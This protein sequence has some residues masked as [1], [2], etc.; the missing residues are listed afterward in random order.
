MLES[1]AAELW[2]PIPGYEWY[3]A[4]DLGRIRSVP[5]VIVDR[6]GRTRRQRGCVLAPLWSGLEKRPA[7]QLGRGHRD[8]VYR[9]VLRTFVGPPPDGMEGCHEDGDVRN[10]KP[11]NLRWG[12][13]SS[14]SMDKQRHGTDHERNKTRCPTDHLLV[15]PNL[16]AHKVDVGHRKCLACARA[17]S[18]AQRARHRNVQF[19]FR[20]DADWR[21]ARIMAGSTGVRR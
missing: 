19:D 2:L 4:S 10:S 12:T 14:N 16:V 20:A 8:Y 6:L 9:L 15:A 11:G 7:V 18:A 3:E 17:H 1:T 5:R 21:Y 13:R